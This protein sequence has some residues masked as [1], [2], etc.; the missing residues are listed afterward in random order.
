MG[1]NRTPTL[2]FWPDLKKLRDRRA[3][4]GIPIIAVPSML[5]PFDLKI[6]R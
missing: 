2:S 1:L 6:D 4:E 3:Y 5:N